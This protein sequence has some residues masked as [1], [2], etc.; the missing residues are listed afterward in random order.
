MQTELSNSNATVLF[1]VYSNLDKH[2]T[3]IV[4]TIGTAALVL[5]DGTPLS[6]LTLDN[7]NFELDMCELLADV[8]E[9]VK[10]RELLLRASIKF[11]DHQTTT[12]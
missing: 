7:I 10:S 12:K 2:D 6:A 9:R 5:L 8:I 1:T 3:D 4:H 11:I